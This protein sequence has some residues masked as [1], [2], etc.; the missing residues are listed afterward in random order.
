MISE[1][2]SQPSSNTPDVNTPVDPIIGI[3][4]TQSLPGNKKR[5]NYLIIGAL[6]LFIG[7]VSG[8]AI[9]AFNRP[10]ASIEKTE[11]IN[12]PSFSD[13]LLD[14]KNTEFQPSV[15]TPKYS[16]S[17]DSSQAIISTE[18]GS[19]KS[20]YQIKRTDINTGKSE[21]IY[22]I[23][24]VIQKGGNSQ[25][26]YLGGHFLDVG[27]RTGF[28]Q[29]K[30]DNFLFSDDQRLLAYR[31]QESEIDPKSGLPNGIIRYV[32]HVFNTETIQ[33]KVIY[34]KT[35][36]FSKLS[37]DPESNT[38]NCSNPTTQQLIEKCFD[39]MVPFFDNAQMLF[40]KDNKRLILGGSIDIAKSPGYGI[41]AL[42]TDKYQDK[43]EVLSKNQT[44]KMPQ[45]SPSGKYLLA[46]VNPHAFSNE[47]EY[48]IDGV[49]D[50]V[51]TEINFI[52]VD[53]GTNKIYYKG[54]NIG[55]KPD[56][57]A[58]APFH[59][60]KPSFISE[61]LIFIPTEKQLLVV[62]VQNN[63]TADI[64]SEA[65]KD[66]TDKK[67]ITSFAFYSQKTGKIIYQV[68]D[69]IS[70]SPQAPCF[71]IN[72]DGSGRQKLDSCEGF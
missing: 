24:I 50:Q 19:I 11:K 7:I 22:D 33:D 3:I 54:Y 65:L 48:T 71:A 61:N 55:V 20:D 6:I 2:L 72:P 37:S 56:S 49:L 17:V 9:Y 68:N 38:L 32:I 4:P 1:L 70:Y 14:T 53:L 57:Q 52:L 23:P 18:A 16:Y 34:Q 10:K 12:K 36:D 66:L 46:E 45:L 35:A 13:I 30:I 39:K 42:D 47:S 28:V 8:G 58:S 5:R 51:T 43:M 64:T 29:T 59:V 60:W 27:F 44:R 25:I 67:I 40:S 21:V 15:S 63:S 41:F 31:S 62:N 69:S 26:F